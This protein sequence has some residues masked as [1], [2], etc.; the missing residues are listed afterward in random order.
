[1]F[2]PISPIRSRLCAEN[3]TLLTQTS[4]KQ[5]TTLSPTRM[6][7]ARDP[8]PVFLLD[9]QSWTHLEPICSL[10]SHPSTPDEMLRL[11]GTLLFTSLT[12]L[13]AGQSCLCPAFDTDF[14]PASEHSD[15]VVS[16]LHCIYSNTRCRY[17]P[18]CCRTVTRIAWYI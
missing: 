3:W 2:S 14:Y 18:V 1:M 7:L 11:F 8:V 12:V 5:M 10:P 9:G 6:D 13:V 15:V 16:T 17:G 4:V